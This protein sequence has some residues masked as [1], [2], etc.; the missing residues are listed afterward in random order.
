M[1]RNY[2]TTGVRALL[3]NRTY[4]VIN[5]F[6]LALGLA[7]CML[8]LLF[9][10]DQLSYDRFVPDAD[11]V[12]QLQES[13]LDPDTGRSGSQQSSPY[14][15]GP[16]M[17]KD[18]PQVQYASYL[19]NYQPIV[20]VRGDPQ[21][22][23]M[24]LVNRD[25]FRIF[26]LPF[27]RGSAAGALRDANSVV[28][29]HRQAGKLFGS[30]DVLGRSV[31]VLTKDGQ[32]AYRVTGVFADVPQNSHNQPSMIALHTPDRLGSGE[33]TSWSW[34]NGYNYVK[35]RPGADVATMEAQLKTWAERNAPKDIVDGRLVSQVSDTTFHLVALADIH[36]GAGKYG[37]VG[38]EGDRGTV[39]TFAVLAMLILV[40]ACVN[41]TNLATA[42]ASQRAREVS[43]RKVLG[44]SRRQ[45]VAQFLTESVI[46][47]ALSMLIALG[48][49]EL[50]LPWL[51]DFLQVDM[52]FTYLGTGGILLPALVLTL[53]V[54]LLG[55][56]YPA[57]YLTR[58][59]PAQVLKA[60]K[61]AA[62]TAGSGRLRNVLVIGQFAISIGLIVCTS[63]VYAQTRYTRSADPG[64]VRTGL[65]QIDN[66]SRAQV[67]PSMEALQREIGRVA[68]VKSVALTQIAMN[69]PSRIHTTLVVPGQ[70]ST[71]L[72]SYS[73]GYGFVETMGI[74]L[75]AG[76][77]LSRSHALDDATTPDPM[78]DADK[79][80]LIS[81]GLNI[82]VTEAGV[83]QLGFASPAAAIG[84]QVGM[85]VSPT[86]PNTVPATIV[87]VVAD[88]RFRGLREIV[89]GGFYYHT[90]DRLPF[91]VVR[92]T[93]P[94]SAALLQRLGAAWKRVVP[95]VPFQ[96]QFS[97]D[98]AAELYQADQALGTM[99]AG[100]ALL[101][102]LIGCLGLFGLAAF[103]A[104]RRT[105]EIGIR[106]V[107]GAKTRD[108]VRLLVWQFSKPV[109]VANL[110][111]WPIAYWVVCRWLNG[112][113]DR[114]ALT[115]L[116]FLL[117]GGL[118][119]AIAVLTV[120]GHATRVA[121]AKP[122]TALR[123]E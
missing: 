108:I 12:Y 26:D 114:I 107:L 19:Y 100:F 119:L 118:A 47:A 113:D 105:K 33:E 81:R 42:R 44:A 5:V 15:A 9:V 37:P 85:T 115:P 48:L 55:G 1:W 16:A 32:K 101:A 35:L 76:R 71:S 92:F 98:A 3:K 116:P 45:L 72:G 8:I 75:L 97:D 13:F 79:Q 18:F 7:A 103:T 20:L 110:I 94:D 2:V 46:V 121:R 6:G 41:F 93:D 66:M 27:V 62:D 83:K 14:A 68:G 117:A 10:R 24:T 60:N 123:Y 25:Y 77:T 34:T 21:Q 84:R 78:T 31:T 56:L 63:V 11:R 52:P 23:T 39:V 90:E 57:F 36:L 87:G 74:K 111:A 67:R 30:D 58:F 82:V 70:P 69:T 29:S 86:P 65:I 64:F 51:R 91:M 104:E 38:N 89:E 106:K 61:S 122:V 43:L 88:P 112:F 99:F 80:A 73:V 54:G 59:Q 50:T 120:A 96:A 40:M 102:V 53:A 95:N 49:V 17:V 109:L 4:A 22:M 28:V